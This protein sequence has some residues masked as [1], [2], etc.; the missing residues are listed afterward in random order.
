MRSVCARAAARYQLSIPTKRTGGQIGDRRGYGAGSSIEFEDH[1]DYAPGDDPRHIDWRAYARTDRLAV[2][3]YREEVA[4]AVDLIIDRSASMAVS[5]AKWAALEDLVDAFSAWGL[6]AGCAMR[7]F[8][9]GGDR[10]A[11]DERSAPP[12]DHDG[13][14]ENRARLAPRG[15]LRRRGLRVVFSDF[16][17]EDDPAPAL[18]KVAT[19][20][21]HLYVI[22]LLTAE[23]L[24]PQVGGTWTMVDAE[25]GGRHEL[26]LDAATVDRYR[27]RLTQL[28]DNVR[29]ETHRLGGTYAQV[30]AAE[31]GVMFAESLLYQGVVAPR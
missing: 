6:D 24:A 19:H 26:S 29:I 5:S 4:P 12:D 30:I 14:D 7:R 1:R 16:L 2:R 25:D 10:L 21:A 22:Q 11:A 20:A 28:C 15:P 27:A 17:F 23:E 13:T 18:R 9:A 3:V 31:P 8:E